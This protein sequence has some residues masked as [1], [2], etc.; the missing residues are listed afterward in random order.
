MFHCSC[1]MLNWNIDHT[2]GCERHIFHFLI[3]NE[4]ETV[5]FKDTS[6]NKHCATLNFLIEQMYPSNGHEQEKP[7]IIYN[8]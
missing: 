1:N 7:E 6:C 3:L 5:F 4:N 2:S 8:L